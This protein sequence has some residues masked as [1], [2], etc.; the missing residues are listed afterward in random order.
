[1]IDLLERSSLLDELAGVLAAT[2]AGG[3]VVLV[4]GEAGIGKSAL[5]KRF[6]ERHSAQARVLLGVCDPLLTPGRSARCTHAR[7]ADRHVS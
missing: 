4:A 5:I 6:S 3:Q 7:V 1:V 2:A